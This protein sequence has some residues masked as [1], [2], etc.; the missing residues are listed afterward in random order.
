MDGD[1][2]PQDRNAEFNTARRRVSAGILENDTMFQLIRGKVEHGNV[3]GLQAS[4]FL[5]EPTY[6]QTEE[7][8]T[9]MGIRIWVS[10]ATTSDI[11]H[12]VG[13]NMKA[14]EYLSIATHDPKKEAA[15]LDPLLIHELESILPGDLSEE[16]RKKQLNQKIQDVYGTWQTAYNTL[17]KEFKGE[18]TID[19]ST[20]TVVLESEL[21]SRPQEHMLPN[22]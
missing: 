6:G 1:P 16:D 4:N 14:S 10:E 18:V 12:S 22:E 13:F 11:T 7:G 5:C 2:I 20:G 17:V 19:P 3:A 8:T 15:D 9:L 21:K